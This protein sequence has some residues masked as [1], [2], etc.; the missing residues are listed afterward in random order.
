MDATPAKCCRLYVG[1]QWIG[2][3]YC[4]VR[5]KNA[6]DIFASAWAKHFTHL[7]HLLALEK[8]TDLLVEVALAA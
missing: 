3:D 7:R 8:R 5:S 1:K 2:P 6:R 4:L